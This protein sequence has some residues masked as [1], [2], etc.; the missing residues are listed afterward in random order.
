MGNE[1]MWSLEEN[2][3]KRWELPEK[4]MGA[5]TKCGSIEF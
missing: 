2:K 5:G 1:K 3:R 4:L